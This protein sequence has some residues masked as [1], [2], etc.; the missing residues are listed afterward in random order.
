MPCSEAW[1][2]A[3][4]AWTLDVR[5]RVRVRARVR[6]RVRVKVRVRVRIRVRV[7]VRVRAGVRVGSGYLAVGCALDALPRHVEVGAGAGDT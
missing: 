2:S 1:A 3:R 4:R 5:V 7:R 6:V